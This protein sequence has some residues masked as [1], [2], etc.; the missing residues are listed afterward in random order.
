[1]ADVT[2]DSAVISSLTLRGSHRSL[3]WT[4]T[5]IGYLFFVDGD[6]DFKYYSTTDGGATWSG[7][8]TI[9]AGVVG[10]Y[11]AWYDRDTPGDT[12]TKIHTVYVNAGTPDIKY[13]ALDTNGDS[14]GTEV[15]VAAPA[16]AAGYDNFNWVTITKALSGHLF[17]GYVVEDSTDGING[18]LE[19]STDGGATFD[20]RTAL[21]ELAIDYFHLLPANTGDNDDICAIYVDV[22]ADAISLKMHNDTLNTWTE[23][24]ID[25]MID[26]ALS[27]TRDQFA[28]AVRHSDN[29]VILAFWNDRD[30]ATADLKCY[31]LTVDSIAL[32]TVTALT[33]VATDKDDMQSVVV[34]IDQNTD[35]IYVGYI[36]KNDGSETLGTSVGIYSQV[37]GD[38]GSTWDAAVARNETVTNNNATALY[39]SL[40]GTSF[41]V[42]YA[43]FENTD[44]DL[45]FNTAVSLAIAPSAIPPGMGTVVGMSELLQTYNA[46]ASLR[47]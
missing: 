37:S 33:N 31:D 36:G 10:A 14:L 38:G 39:G 41:R 46:G 27:T 6:S 1:M 9:F 19:R 17:V 28:A 23:T 7:P 21:N 22:S 25:A 11:D 15:A 24:A 13:R 32:P 8:T 43:W 12:G 16:G 20:A 3:K 40:G 47:Y 26:I 35:D 44:D 34:S 29:H 18:G 45:M 2:I 4:T 30:T 42:G 5:L